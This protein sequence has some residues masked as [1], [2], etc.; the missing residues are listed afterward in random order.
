[1][2]RRLAGASQGEKDKKRRKDTLSGVFALV[3][4]WYQKIGNTVGKTP[5]KNIEDA[6]LRLAGELSMEAISKKGGTI[7]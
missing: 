7:R 2:R 6:L 4:R 3:N 1:M 5:E